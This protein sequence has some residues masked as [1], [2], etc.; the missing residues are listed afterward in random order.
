MQD[1]NTGESA[2]PPADHAAHTAPAEL[3]PIKKNLWQRWMAWSGSF[4]VLSILAHVILLGGATV[5]VVQVVQGRKE[6]MKF[7]APPPSPAGMSEH[8]VKP[9]KKTAAA[10]AISKR[11]ASSAANASIALPAMDMNTPSGPDVMASV[12]SGLGSA[13]L[14]GGPGGAAGMASMPLAGLTAFGFKGATHGGLVGHFYDLK[15]TADRKPAASANEGLASQSYYKVIGEFLSKNWDASVLK[16]YYCAPDSML[17]VQ[18]YMPCSGSSGAAKAFGVEK[19]TKSPHWVIHYTGQVVAPD[20]GEYRFWG[21]CDDY[22][23]VRFDGKPVLASSGILRA[24]P[25]ESQKFVRPEMK[26]LGTSPTDKK[27]DDMQCMPGYMAAKGSWFRVERG[28]SYPIDILIG[29][30]GGL[31][32]QILLIQERFPKQP[33]PMRTQ[34]PLVPRLPLV[35]FRRGIPMPTYDPDAVKKAGYGDEYSRNPEPA[36]FSLIFTAK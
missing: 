12:M 16:R 35:Q 14:G 30:T 19:E 17:A 3:H 21:S 34:P 29:D 20:D 15:Q 24:T 23:A 25:P 33:Y 9:S 32:H 11:I 8:K 28:K 5:L 31:Y 22:M 18:M 13:G 36:P 10:P 26:P 6:K 1:G 7:T 2:L 27:T 4:L